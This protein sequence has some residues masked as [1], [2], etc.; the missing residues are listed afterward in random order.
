MAR[1]RRRREPLTIVTWLWDGPREYRPKYVNVLYR[2]VQQHL[3]LEHRFVCVYDD[4]RFNARYFDPGIELMPMPDAARD[5][6]S[7]KSIS[8]QEHPSCFARLW[9]LSQEAAEAFPGRVF[10]FDVDSIPIG[11]M[12]GL[13]EYRSDADFI[14]MR[15]VPSSGRSRP[16]ITGGSWILRSGAFTGLWDEFMAD[17]AKARADAAEWFLQG[18]DQRLVGWAGGSDQSFLSHRLIP[19]MTEDGPITY[20]RDDCGILLWDS[21]RKQRG[22]V[23]GCLLHFNG[24]H[25]PWQLEWT[26]TRELYGNMEYRVI[27]RPLPYGARKY[28]VG[29]TFLARNK[30]DARALVLMRRI[31][32]AG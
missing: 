21:F 14:T 23:P 4:K 13:V 6:I 12:S 28:E 10:M 20:W 32:V 18:N 11:D 5:L 9:H 27:N 16:Y 30:H 17:P 1:R 7:L 19:Q 31:E 25:K 3:P 15:R 26:L 8:G 2:L 22:Q 24:V 29:E